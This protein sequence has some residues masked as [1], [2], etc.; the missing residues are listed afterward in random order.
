MPTILMVKGWRFYFYANERNEPAHVHAR[1]A[2]MECKYWL[3]SAIFDVTE[4]FAFGMGPKDRREVRQIIFEHFTQIEAEWK[5][6]QRRKN[7]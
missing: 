4:A 3:R 5:A 2:D 6:F 7:P 1:K